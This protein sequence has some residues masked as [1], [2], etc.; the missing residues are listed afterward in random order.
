[1]CEVVK[2][3]VGIDYTSGFI[4]IAKANYKNKRNAHFI[5]L[6]GTKLSDLEVKRHSPY[7]VILIIG[8]FLYIHNK[9]GRDVLRQALEVSADE[10]LIIIREP[11][12]VEKEVVL[13]NVWSEDM[14][15]YYSARYRTRGWFIRMFNDVL[16]EEGYS[17]IVDEALFPEHLNNRI[18]SRQHLFVLKKMAK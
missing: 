4:D 2:K 11:I 9:E 12:A 16:F 18:E 13:D 5:C 7:T 8:F 6:D 3:Y 1:M 15:T 10:S 14:G 17:L